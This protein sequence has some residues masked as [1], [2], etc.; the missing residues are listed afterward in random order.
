MDVVMDQFLMTGTNARLQ[1]SGRTVDMSGFGRMGPGTN[2]STQMISSTWN[3]PGILD[4]EATFD[5]LGSSYIFSLLQN[6][7]FRVLGAPAGSTATLTLGSNSTNHGVIDVTSEGGGFTSNLVLAPGAMLQNDGYLNFQPGAGGPRGFDGHLRSNAPVAVNTNTTFKNG[8]IELQGWNLTIA[9]AIAMTVDGGVTMTMS[10]GLLDVQG[11]FQQ[12]S[13]TFNFDGGSVPNVADLVHSTLSIGAT[14]TGV[15]IFDVHGVT[16]L[17][18]DPVA[19]QHVTVM[20]SPSGS[21]AT[22]TIP[23]DITLAG[24][25]DISSEGGGYSGSLVQAAT[26]T[27][28]NDG[29]LRVLAG[30]GGPRALKGAIVNDGTL[31]VNAATVFRDGPVVN[32]GTWTIGATG[33][34]NMLNGEDFDQMAGTFTADGTFT[35]VGGTDSFLGGS[36]VGQPVL[37]H[38]TLDF[39]TG[40]FLAAAD[41]RLEGSSHLTSDVPAATTLRLLG[42]SGG[43]TQ[44]LTV[45]IASVFAGTTEIAS[46]DGGYASNLVS[47]AGNSITNDGILRS[48]PGSGGPRSIKGT[49]T[50][51]GTVEIDTGTTLRDGPVVNN[52]SWTVSSGAAMDMLNGEDFDQVAGTFAVDG[53]FTHVSGTVS[54]LGGTLTGQ[55]VL[56]H[57]TLDFAPATFVA[58]ASLRLEG[59]SSLVSDVPAATTLQLFGASGGSTQTLTIPGSVT[60]AGTTELTAANGGYASNLTITSGMLATNTGTLRCSTG[61]GGGRNISGDLLNQGALEID[62]NTIYSSGTLTNQGGIVIA[63]GQTFSLDGGST[64]VQEAGGMGVKGSFVHTGGSDRFIAGKV[65]GQLLLRHSTLE[66]DSAFSTPISLRMEGN[67]SFSGAIR[68]GQELDLVGA[69][70]GSTQTFTATGGLLSAGTL[71]MSSSSGGFTTNLVVNGGIFQNQGLVEVLLGAGGNRKITA[72]VENSGSI[73]LQGASLTLQGATSNLAG[74]TISGVGTLLP[75]GTILNDGIFAP[76]DPVGIL[77]VTGNWTQAAGG[78]LTID[79]GGLVAGT[80]HDQLTVSSTATLGGELRLASINGFTPQFGDTFQVMTAGAISGTFDTV[81]YQGVLNGAHRIELVYTGTTVTAQVVHKNRAIDPSRVPLSLSEPSP[82]IAGQQNTFQV[83]GAAGYGTVE[84]VYG[85]ALGTTPTATC[86][87]L[88][89]GIGSAIVLGS[90]PGSRHGNALLQVA[91]TAGLA[92]TT[93]YLQAVDMGNCRTTDLVTF[94]FP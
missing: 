22:A 74:G 87:G 52:G 7:D 4:N 16:T 29:L 82:G 66:F 79:L 27:F 46:V 42:A 43:S 19:G 85:I 56:R 17:L 71:R 80:D 37:R 12:T 18:G 50:N 69:P 24:T 10:G 76:G 45:D 92:G 72:D 73:D 77:G 53:S 93:G 90:A 84:L 39:D 13:G 9:P 68:A 83:S 55:P 30:A 36:V 63:T 57:T 81:R 59:S 20:G 25:L 2:I 86:T 14:S 35:H 88:D 51:N 89:F 32:N 48:L 47:T 78:R 26:T 62:T 21:S 54:F 40:G 15:G 23:N 34:M 28:T 75:S 8:P 94:L 6:G 3:G 49:F 70:G 31:E 60:L 41:I 38:T 58:P 1:L 33:A 65:K 64:F 67:N 11:S 44:T 5:A 61:S 91:V